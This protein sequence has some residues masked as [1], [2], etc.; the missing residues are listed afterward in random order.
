[1]RYWTQ[2]VMLIMF[3]TLATMAIM[4]MYVHRNDI[5][6]PVFRIAVI[7][8]CGWTIPGLFKM[9]RMVISSIV[10]HK[11]EVLKNEEEKAP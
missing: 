11:N 10:Q 8:I 6:N 3:N 4:I 9:Y 1:M 7:F 2:I 5:V